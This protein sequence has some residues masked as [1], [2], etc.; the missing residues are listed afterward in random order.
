MKKNTLKLLAAAF[1]M[2]TTAVVFQSCSNNDDE[3][4]IATGIASDPNNFK[5][6]V[7]SG[8]TVTL[9]PTKVYKLTG[10][11]AV[12]AGG[13]L[14]IPAG[15]RIEASGGTSA[16]ITVE[17]D[18]K[19]FANGTASSPIVMTSPN[20]TPGS[21]GGL[22]ICGK[23]PINK[24][25]T[26]TAEVGNATYGGTNVSDN[27][28]ILKFVRIEYAGAIFT[29]DK[30]F[31]G[32]SL[33]GVGNGTTIDNISL[34][35]GSDDGIEFFGGTVNVSNI[36]S[37]ANEDDAF[38]WTEGWNGTATNIYT[39]RRA[40][41]VGNRGIEADNNSLDNN[42]NP[43]SNPTIKNA[44]FIGGTT[45]EADALKLR[46]G[47]YGTFDNLVLSNWATGINVEH[48]ASVAYFNG[49]NKITN[50]KFDT[51]IATKASAKNTAGAAVTILANTY[52]E[53]A[54]ATGAGNGINTPTWAT[55][56]A[57]L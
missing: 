40:N 46:V 15:T 31:N 20:P 47:T 29:G 34:I 2:S 50:V 1:I 7:K 19:I 54:S 33:F 23:A 13:T 3:E 5:G 22:V 4:I 21:W 30:E 16:Y 52:S 55:G 24:G 45:G 26:A 36:V 44:T 12:K 53:N 39:K 41:G 9:D 49:G 32:L 14:V 35:N 43:R 51:N 42:A 28:G 57:G 48:D 6:E 56:W 11:V 10:A 25:T 27:S 8:E 38:D 37:V 17:Q 18:G